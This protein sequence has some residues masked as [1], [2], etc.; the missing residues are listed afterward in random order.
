MAIKPRLIRRW[1]KECGKLGTITRVE[2]LN[3][4]E[5]GN[6]DP[7]RS[8]WGNVVELT[9]NGHRIS[10]YGSNWYDAWQ[11]AAYCAR[12]AAEEPPFEAK[13]QEKQGL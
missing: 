5:N 3:K 12:W 2:I 9:V 13:S 4:D 11:G 1:K 7:D 6:I 8:Q 10:A